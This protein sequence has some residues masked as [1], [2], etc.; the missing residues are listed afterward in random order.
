MIRGAAFAGIVLLVT[1]PAC[2]RH[3]DA[4]PLTYTACQHANAVLEKER[5]SALALEYVY[6]RTGV[7]TE[8]PQISVTL[9]PTPFDCGA[10]KSPR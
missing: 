7:T 2:V 8:L 3:S 1:L 6:N 10:S 9:P 4:K 5:R